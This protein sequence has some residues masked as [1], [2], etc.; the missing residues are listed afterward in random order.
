MPLVKTKL[1]TIDKA[2]ISTLVYYDVLNFPLTNFEVF[3]NLVSLKRID[4][5]FV[6]K[7]GLS[8]IDNSL[9]RFKKS[10]VI[11]EFNGLYHLRKRN[12]LYDIRIER[13]KLADKKWKKVIFALKFLKVI[14]YIRL[15]FA[16]GSL[17]LYNTDYDSDLDIFLVVRSG[18][19]WTSRFLISLVMELL[20]VRRSKYDVVGKD[21]V[22]SN[23]YITDKSLE[24]PCQ[25]IY[26][27]QLYTHLTPIIIKDESLLKDFWR[28]NKWVNN[29]M[30]NWPP[31]TESNLRII[32]SGPLTRFAAYIS[33]E[34]LDF[35]FGNWL[36]RKL[37]D[38]QLRRIKSDS[39]SPN[40]KGRIVIDDFQ[41][42]FHP[43]SPEAGI[44]SYYNSKMRELGF[45][46][47]GKEEDSGLA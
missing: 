42:E 44:I 33:E 32:K 26:T 23:H 7:V 40:G 36:E 41:L 31:F 4:N 25:S 21:L 29:Y 3:K 20:G 28:E 6:N 5:K 8:D 45:E 13:R 24:I 27:A 30:N 38:F 47:L 34:I 22:C 19:I 18:R 43:D 10:K 14:P 2:V 1:T 9:L 12:K 15:V 11:D 35:T 39:K 16:S 46:E 17:A 37:K